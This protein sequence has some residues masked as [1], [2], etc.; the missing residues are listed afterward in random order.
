MTVA[1]LIGGMFGP[2]LPSFD[3]VYGVYLLEILATS[4]WGLLFGISRLLKK[5]A[6]AAK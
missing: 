6:V 3:L 5:D 4:V 1:Q 2:L